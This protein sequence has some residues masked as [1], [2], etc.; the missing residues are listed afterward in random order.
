[1]SDKLSIGLTC[2]GTISSCVELSTRSAS[3]LR[4]SARWVLPLCGTE[5]H[6]Q[7]HVFLHEERVVDEPVRLYTSLYV[8]SRRDSF[9][10]VN[11]YPS[12]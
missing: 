5:R 6:S 4:V 8:S 3:L 12:W 2:P 1:M 9:V 10:Q 7:A 11:G